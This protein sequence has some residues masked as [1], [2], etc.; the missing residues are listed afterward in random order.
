MVADGPA[1]GAGGG[2]FA[3]TRWSVVLAAGQA[4]TPSAAEA[5][6]QLCRAYW[7]PLYAFARRSGHSPAD[8]EDAIQ[9]FFAALIAKNSL[10]L[11]DP[12]RGRFRTFL[13]AALQNFLTREW[14]RQRSQKRGGGL[15]LLSVE[16]LGPEALYARESTHA[17]SP[18][19]LYDRAW[20]WQLLERARARLRHEYAR[21]GHAERFA[22]LESFLPGETSDLTYAEAG[23]QLGLSE[24]TI[25]AEVHR[26]KKRY[27]TL[28][29]AMIAPTVDGTEDIEA[30]L[31]ALVAALSR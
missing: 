20:A 3:T 15:P 10:R 1:P 23:R 19:Q 8:A 9:S 30:E 14:H 22:L 27:G 18:E 4:G 12:A 6:D 16:E 21:R 11:A 7:Y 31:Q 28:L 5:V 26:F 25:K 29:R 24:G 13:L 2:L 17:L